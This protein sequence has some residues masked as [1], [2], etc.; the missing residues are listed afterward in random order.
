MAVTRED[1]V[2][3]LVD[4]A[5][6]GSFPFD[7]VRLM[8]ACFVTAMAGREGWR[9]LFNFRP[10]DYGPFDPGV[11]RSR[12]ELVAQGLLDE[13]R[14]G[15]YDAYTLTDAGHARVAAIED[16][17]GAESAQWLRRVGTWVASKSFN[18]LLDDIYRKWPEYATQSVHR[19]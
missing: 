1:L 8:K 2:L 14:V 12:D 18:R 17:L 4:G 15:R 3:V 13:E 9:P 10:Y 11:Y 16:E 5:D 7:P 6:G 19:A